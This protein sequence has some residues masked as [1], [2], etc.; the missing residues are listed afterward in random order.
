MIARSPMFVALL[1]LFAP[2]AATA[3]DT[4]PGEGGAQVRPDTAVV[5]LVL[6]REA[7]TYPVFARRNPFLPLTSSDETG[8][9][10]DQMRLTGILFDADD[11][12][13]SIAVISAGT[14]AGQQSGGLGQN[15]GTAN[16]GLVERLRVGERWGNVRIVSIAPDAVTVDV[17]DFGIEERRVMR[18]QSRSQG[19]S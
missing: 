17:S 15:Q 7:F 1:A 9:R 13:R 4:P 6:R 19:G 10:F 3:Q 8:P 16:R 18:L 14:G 2:A 5:E 12:L 11:P